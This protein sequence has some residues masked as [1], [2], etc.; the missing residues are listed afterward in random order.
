MK[1]EKEER[2][3]GGR[4]RTEFFVELNCLLITIVEVFNFF[5]LL[6]S[7]ALPSGAHLINFLKL[8]S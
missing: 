5:A 2:G 7:F 1:R 4:E 3:G 8:H 6:L